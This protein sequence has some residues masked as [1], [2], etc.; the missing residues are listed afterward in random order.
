MI[1]IKPRYMYNEKE[2]KIGVLIKV[3]EF[4]QLIDELEDVYDYE[5]IKKIEGK[6]TKVIPLEK[7]MAMIEKRR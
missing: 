7:V 4:E 6:K 3:E 5:Y 1:K 2:E